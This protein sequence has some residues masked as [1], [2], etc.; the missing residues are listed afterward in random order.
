MLQ[1]LIF[2]ELGGHQVPSSLGKSEIRNVLTTFTK[3]FNDT[4]GKKN[5][6]RRRRAGESRSRRW[7]GAWRASNVT[8]KKG[9]FLSF[10]LSPMPAPLLYTEIGVV[11]MCNAHSVWNKDN[12]ELCS[13]TRAPAANRKEVESRGCCRLGPLMVPVWFMLSIIRSKRI[14]S[15]INIWGRIYFYSIKIY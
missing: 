15:A 8:T 11:E 2:F 4:Q 12:K 7:G 14:R 13:L 6:S 3:P 9:M 1:S 5:E 10:I